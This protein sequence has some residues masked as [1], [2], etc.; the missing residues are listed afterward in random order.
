MTNLPAI[1]AGFTSINIYRSDTST[2]QFQ[3]AGNTTSTSFTD[4]NADSSLGATLNSNTLASGNYSYYV[5]YYNSTTGLESRPTQ[6]VGP[7]SIS[8]NGRDIALSNIPSPSSGDFDS[9]RIYRNTAANPTNYYLTATLPAGTSTYI[10]NQPDSAI[11]GNAQVNLDGPAISAA[12]LLTNLVE[13][14]GS[15][16]TQPFQNATQVQFTGT[17][18]GATLATKTLN[19]TSTTTVQDLIDFVDQASGIQPSSADSQNP[20]PGNPGGSINTA[21]SSIQ[22]TSDNGD[23]NAVSIGL[24]ALQV[25]TPTGTSAVNLNFNTTQ[26]AVGTGASTNVVVYDSLGDPIN[27]TIN[28]VLESSSASGTVY[29][30]FADSGEN[31][32]ASGNSIAVGTGEVEFD[33]QGNLVS[34]TNDQISIGRAG[35]AAEPLQFN[36]NFSSVSGLSISSSTLA[37]SRQDGSATGTLSSFTIDG[38][39]LIT[40]VFSNGVTRTLGQLQLAQFANDQG[41]NQ[42]GQNLYSAGVDSG[43]P[44]VGTPGAQGAGS[45]VAGALEQSN[46]DIG[47][48]LINLI[49]ASTEYRSSAQI[50]STVQTLYETLLSLRT[51]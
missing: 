7:Q 15:T 11:S 51:G 3:L 32:P 22:F 34:V 35:S 2:N 9:V 6:L 21:N 31:Q 44:I 25:V 24:S 4:T 50:I 13:R 5:T 38:S 48:N 19:V 49:T 16:Y 12:T 40:G 37:A 42:Q 17:K 36:L 28:T 20:L 29:R 33:G 8:L 46:T 45:I 30:W 39:G 23:P 18:G 10:D 27:V 14:N 41:L 26:T 47:N 43:L 1:P